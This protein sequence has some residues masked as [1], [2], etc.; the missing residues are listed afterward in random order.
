VRAETRSTAP[1]LVPWLNSFL[2]SVFIRFTLVQLGA[3]EPE[4]GVGA[5]GGR[6]A[7]FGFRV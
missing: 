2:F 3:V 5:A 6:V 1:E 7:G 4:V